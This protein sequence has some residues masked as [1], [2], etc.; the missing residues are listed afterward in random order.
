VAFEVPWDLGEVDPE[1]FPVPSAV[2][3]GR[4]VTSPTAPP[5]LPLPS[6][7]LRF[8]GRTGAHGGWAVAAT[9]LAITTTEGERAFSTDDIP[10]SLYAKRFRQGASLV[11]RMLVF[12]VDAPRGPVGMP[13]GLRAVR[14][15]RGSLDKV[16]WRGLP[17]QNGVLEGIFVRPCYLGEHVLPFRLLSPGEAVIPY[18]GARLLA[19]A[20][21]RIDRYPGLAEW[22]RGAEDVWEANKGD[23]NRLTLLGRL[24][25][26]GEL[27][28]QFPTSPFRITYTKAGNYLTAAIVSDPQAIIDHKLYW[29][30]TTNQDEARYLTALLNAPALGDL[31]RPY[32]SVGA[33]GPRDFDKYVWYAPVPEFD[34]SN[35]RHRH[36]VDLAEESEAVA[37]GL[38][39]PEGLGFQRAR[40][41]IRQALEGLGTAEA[42]NAEF[43]ALLG[44]S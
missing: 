9:N 22:W 19:G 29:M 10:R 33:F 38:T 3:L 30:G 42:I 21:D 6:S 43:R 37:T 31:I 2:V 15:R 36:L 12:V 27:S 5:R 18:D 7:R 40:K 34:P 11:P 23:A 8:S 39:L 25:F 17:D 14:S 13:Q 44:V 28:A 20:D 41:L 4:R 16:P 32:Q 24:D 1:P 26:N 35:E